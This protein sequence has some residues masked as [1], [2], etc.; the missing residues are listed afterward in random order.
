[1]KLTDDCL[2]MWKSW[3]V[4]GVLGE[5]RKSGCKEKSGKPDEGYDDV[6]AR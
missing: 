6:M 2:N 1:M 5:W 4:Q 3:I